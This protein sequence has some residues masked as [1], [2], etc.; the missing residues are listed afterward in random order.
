MLNNEHDVRGQQLL[1]RYPKYTK[2]SI[3]RHAKKPIGERRVDK[4]RHNPGRTRKLSER[5][6]DNFFCKKLKLSAELVHRGSDEL[7]RHVI[8][9]HGYSYRNCRKGRY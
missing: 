4:R 6:E 5:D 8:K 2:V 1:N 3:Y 7:I 9:R